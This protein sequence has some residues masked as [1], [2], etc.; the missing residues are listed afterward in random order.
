MKLSMSMI[1]SYLAHHNTESNL[2]DNER[3]IHG[4]RFLSSGQQRSSREYVYIGQARDYLKDPEY[5]DA[6]ILASG[7]SHIVCRGSDYEELLNDVLSAFDYFNEIEQRLMKAAALGS[8]LDE[9]LEATD[10]TLREPFMVF[11]IDGTLLA[12][13]RLDRLS[14]AQLRRNLEQRGSLGAELIG[15]Y[16]TDKAG[17]VQHDLT[18]FARATYGPDGEVAVSRY[19][20][21]DGERTGFIMC[22]PH[23][24]AK[25][26]LAMSIEEAFAPYLAQA[27]E[28]TDA[29]SPYQSQHLA[30]SDLIG[31]KEIT[32]EAHERLADAVGRAQGYYLVCAQSLAIRN[33]TQRLLLATEIEKSPT[34]CLACEVGD[35]V[36]FLVNE[37][38]LSGLVNQIVRRFDAKSAAIGISMPIASIVRAPVAWRQARFSSESAADPGVRYCRDL[39]LPFLLETLRNEPATAD[40][41]HP[42]LAALSTYDEGARSDLPQT[43]R[44]YVATGCNQ[45]ECARRLHVH[46]NTLKYRLR[47][48]EEL[49]GLD[50]KDQ[51]DLFYL[52]LSIELEQ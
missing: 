13:T 49:T 4:M 19:L 6:L 44:T 14:N 7:K 42:A 43:L 33:R 36:A 38:A 12:A 41:L 25:I 48:I 31:G 15:G 17:A 37:N 1:E 50:L 11:G 8:P 16:F 27:G 40:L 32:H 26:G 2:Q 5:A 51:D 24:E 18:D 3:T 47:R 23:D 20:S 10:P 22:F 35:A 52:R 30:L 34:S 28:F 29:L 9:M 39:A 21:Q 46:L 45:A